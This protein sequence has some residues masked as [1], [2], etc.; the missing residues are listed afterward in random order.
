MKTDASIVNVCLK[1][2]IDFGATL[3]MPLAPLIKERYSRLTESEIK[4]IVKTCVKARTSAYRFVNDRAALILS[5]PQ[6]LQSQFE[7]HML[8]QFDWIDANNLS[9]LYSQGCY[10]AMK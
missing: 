9:Q 8:S 7:Q 1:M 3:G 5:S 2:W 4:S 6:N 10:I